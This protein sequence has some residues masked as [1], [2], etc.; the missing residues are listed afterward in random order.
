[1]DFGLQYW[2]RHCQK[3]LLLIEYFI[4]HHVCLPM[5]E[6]IGLPS[7]SEVSADVDESEK[8]DRSV[9]M[10]VSSGEGTT[11]SVREGSTTPAS[12]SSS[13]L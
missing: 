13:Y 6:V 3:D 12:E 2:I 7:V 9:G 5:C 1:M 8:S 10:D 4:S 11:V